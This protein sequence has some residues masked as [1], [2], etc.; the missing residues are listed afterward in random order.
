MS[1]KTK[2]HRDVF[3]VTSW[4]LRQELRSIAANVKARK[5][6][7]GRQRRRALLIVDE[8]RLAI[9]DGKSCIPRKTAE[10]SW[11]Q[12]EAAVA[13]LVDAVNEMAWEW[14]DSPTKFGKAIGDYISFKM[15]LVLED[16]SIAE[17]ER[18]SRYGLI[19]EL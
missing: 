2:T 11:K 3:N 13:H 1:H 18:Q 17:E 6:L 19:R 4:S 7:T 12:S 15:G 14:I 10:G 8:L 5:S 16:Y 9:K